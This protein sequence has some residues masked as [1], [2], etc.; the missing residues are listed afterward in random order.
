MCIGGV[1]VER[2]IEPAVAEAQRDI[3]REVV[4]VGDVAVGHRRTVEVDISHMMVVA[5]L[6][7]TANIPAVE[8]VTIDTLG[9][10]YAPAGMLVVGHHIAY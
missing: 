1:A 5:T 3:G 10:A 4:G 6:H 8:G 9:A 7:R 2:E